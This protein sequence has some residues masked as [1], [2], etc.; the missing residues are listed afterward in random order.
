MAVAETGGLPDPGRAR[1]LDDLAG[2]LRALKVWAGDPSYETITRRINGRRRT[3]GRPE[4]ERAR[5]GTVVDCFKAG[6]RRVDEELVLEV[7]EALHAEPGYLVHWQQALRAAVAGAR[8]AAQVRVLDRLPDDVPGFV[9][10]DAELARLTAHGSLVALITGMAGVGKTQLAIHAGHLLAAEQRFETTLF[11]DL[12][13]FHPDPAQPPA[14]PGAVLDAFLRLLGRPGHRIPPGLPAKVALFTELLAGTRTLLVL[15]NAADEEQLRPLLPA[16]GDAVT[17]VTSRRALPR[18]DADVRLDLDVLSAG[19]AEALLV[20]AA[21]GLAIGADATAYRRLTTRCGRLPL[22]LSVV[23][24]QLVGR[25]G[26]TVTDHADRLDERSRDR[27]LETGVELALHLSYQHLPTPRQTL[28]RRLAAHPG[29]DFDVHACAALLGVGPDEAGAALRGLVDE[30]LVQRSDAERYVLHDL[31][32]AYAAERARDDERPSDRRDALTRLLDHLL[33]AA[34]AAMN[35]LSPAERHRRPELPQPSAT[36][37][38]FTDATDA[39][40]WLDGER[41]TLI[42][43]CAEAA[44]AGRAEYVVRMAGTIYTYLDNGGYPADAV[45][46]HTRARDAARQ[47]GDDVAEAVALTNLGMAWWQLGDYATAVSHLRQALAVHRTAGDLRGEARA[48]GNLGVVYSTSGRGDLAAEY[49]RRALEVFRQVGD[50]VGEANTVTNLAAAHAQLGHP[51]EAI[52]YSRQGL[53]LFR[54][55]RHRGGEATALTNLGDGHLALDECETSVE[56]Y[57]QAL[58]IFRDLGERYGECCA[59]NGLGRAL[60]GLRRG[61]E[62]AEC[63]RAALALALEIDNPDEQQRATTALAHLV[64]TGDHDPIGGCRSRGTGP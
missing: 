14:D 25:P 23:A 10:R 20:A 24:G 61:D 26:W 58:T 45:T 37:L 53:V 38:E 18:L 4:H 46:V 59:L 15:D 1:S 41:T 52:E 43:A 7:V 29:P 54:D 56:W 60:A 30:H 13:G 21:P 63:H 31:V 2:C 11:V 57:R 33:H 17:V 55:L 36:H 3:T 12:R 6:R 35:T 47:L 49:Q 51:A 32:G 34:A 28:L 22:A 8:A 27:R 42:A 64:T 44:G 19:E 48:L 50:R 62:A 5:R 40:A 16:G 9:G 39:R